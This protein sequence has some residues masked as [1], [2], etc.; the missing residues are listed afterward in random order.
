VIERYGIPPEL[1]PDFYGLKG[2]TSDNIPGIPGIG[3]KTAAELLQRFGSLEAILDRVDEVSGE[4]RRE[5]VRLHRDDAVVSKQLATMRRRSAA[6]AGPRSD[7]RGRAR[8]DGNSRHISP[9]RAARP[10]APIGGGDRRD[11]CR[12]RPGSARDGQAPH[13]DA[14]SAGRARRWGARRRRP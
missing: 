5:N 10:A 2:D 6:R 3:E 4:K 14:R 11:R 13:G 8:Y 9:L 1:I 12:R 7:Q